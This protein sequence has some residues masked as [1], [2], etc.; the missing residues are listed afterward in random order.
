[1]QQFSRTPSLT[2]TSRTASAKDFAGGRQAPHAQVSRRAQPEAGERDAIDCPTGHVQRQHVAADGDCAIVKNLLARST[3]TAAP[4]EVDSGVEL[5]RAP[6]T[7]NVTVAPSWPTWMAPNV[8]PS[9]SAP[10]AFAECVPSASL[11]RVAPGV[12]PVAVCC[13]PFSEIEGC[14]DFDE[15]HELV[16]DHRL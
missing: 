8:M 15:L 10:S 14:R 2:A 16:R 5:R 12:G 1:L 13:A 7:L 11:S 3:P 4:V 9:S 6:C